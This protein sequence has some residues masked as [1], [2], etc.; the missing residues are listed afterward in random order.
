VLLNSFLG[1]L[2]PAGRRARNRL[3]QVTLTVPTLRCQGCVDRIRDALRELPAVA[4][5]EGD[6]ARKRLVVT[7]HGD[8]GPL[9]PV[10][11][12]IVRLGHVVA[13]GAR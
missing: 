13:H 11:E 6:P 4:A 10:E 9:G 8:R 3:R 5:V 2:V 12:T 1:R 7:V